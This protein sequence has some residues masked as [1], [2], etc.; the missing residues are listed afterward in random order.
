M[1]DQI[2]QEMMVALCLMAEGNEGKKLLSFASPANNRHLEEIANRLEREGL[3]PQTLKT[4]IENLFQIASRRALEE[5]HPAWI[6]EHLSQESPRL[7]ALLSHWLSPTKMGVVRELVRRR[8]GITVPH[9]DREISVGLLELIKGLVE[10]KLGV[11][12]K[13]PVR[14]NFSFDQLETLKGEDLVAL[15]EELGI[16]EI[17]KAFSEVEPNL[18]KA[19]LSRFPM[20][21]ATELRERLVVGTTVSE[22]EKKIAQKRLLSLPLGPVSPQK[23][24]FEVGSSLF[25]KA[26]RDQDWSWAVRCCHKLPVKEGYRLQRLIQGHRTKGEKRDD[27]LRDEILETLKVLASRGKVRRYWKDDREMEKTE[28]FK[29]ENRSHG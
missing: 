20:L 29:E 2:R 16:E 19:F 14:K 23:L 7:L 8:W 13:R 3:N 10:K 11:E 17:R 28:F 12:K 15:L 25:A 18:F 5:M 4:R 9:P 26:L 1:S 22:E 6:V 24:F 27:L 21:Q